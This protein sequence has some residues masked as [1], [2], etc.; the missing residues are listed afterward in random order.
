MKNRSFLL[1]LIF[2]ALYSFGCEKKGDDLNNIAAKISG[3]Y[4][5]DYTYT[6]AGVYKA[7]IKLT[8]LSDSTVTLSATI[9]GDHRYDY[10][11]KLNEETNGIITLYY[12]SY[13]SSLYGAIDGKQLSYSYGYTNQFVGVKP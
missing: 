1:M 5:G 2:L 9:A 10:K 3:T 6:G 8:R 4:Y 12:A 11:V 13:N 7:E